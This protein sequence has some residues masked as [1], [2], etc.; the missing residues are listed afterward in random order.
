VNRRYL[1]FFSFMV[2]GLLATGCGND[3]GPATSGQT[4]RG[5]GESAAAVVAS[6]MSDAVGSRWYAS[7]SVEHG[8]AIFTDNCAACHGKKAN[9]HFTWR[10]R[11]PDGKYPPP[12]LNGTGHAWHHPTQVLAKQIKF[13]TPGGQGTMPGF[14]GNLSDK[15]VV[16]VIAWFQ[17]LWS[18]KIYDNWRQIEG[19]AR[20]SVQ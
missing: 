5:T 1:S 18:D 8:A 13:G 2:V 6:S 16:D 17:S 19:R 10:Q 14:A 12:P 15:D 7:E 20:A 4:A 3:S 11:G 9:G